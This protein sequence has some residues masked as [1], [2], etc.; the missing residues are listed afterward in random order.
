LP[1]YTYVRKNLKIILILYS[2][3][4]KNIVKSQLEF[5][6]NQNLLFYNLKKQY[7]QLLQLFLQNSKKNDNNF[8]SLLNE[9]PS[10]IDYFNNINTSKKSDLFLLNKKTN[11]NEIEDK[12]NTVQNKKGKIFN[13]KK[14]KDREKEAKEEKR[15]KKYIYR[16]SKYRGVSRNGKTW[17]VLIMI[18]RNKNYIGNFKSEED[19]AKAYDEFA[20]K[21][22]KNKARLNFSHQGFIKYVN[23][24]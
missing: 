22:H 10:S 21:Y 17:Q 18:N 1:K 3:L 12:Q 19:A 13:I 24:P 20:M 9:R 7:N 4:Q 16:G 15:L 23:K 5:E 8:F 6:M 2:E 14:I 11:R